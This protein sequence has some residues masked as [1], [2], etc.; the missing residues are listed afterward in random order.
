[1]KKSLLLFVAVAISLFTMNAQPK[2]YENVA[3]LDKKI[4]GNCVSIDV[5]ASTKDAQKIMT[6]LLKSN[7]LTGKSSK[8]TLT[9]E[10][11]VFS[12]ISTDYI[13]LFVTF[14]AKGKSKNN[15]ITKVNVFVQKGI[16]T[17]FESSNTDQSLV[18]NLKNFL[19]TKY[20]QEVH[21]NDVAIRIANQNKDIKKTQNEINKMEAKLKQRTKDISTYENNIKKANEDIEKLKKD[22]EAQKQLIEKQNQILKEIK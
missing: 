13:N 5:T 22:I 21:N 2:S 16:S 11:I 4:S 14:E 7:R 18:S 12:E 6:D 17:T 10:K 3:N 9:Y 20:V 19:D 15:P 1:M 8:R